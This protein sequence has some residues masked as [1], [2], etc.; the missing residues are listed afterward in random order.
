MLAKAPGFTLTV[1][2]TLGLGIGANAAVFSVINVLL[3]RPL[4]V[5]DGGNL[6]VLTSVHQGN[7]EPHTVS[8]KDYVDVREHAG[9]FSDLTA[10]GFGF[11]GMSVDGH[12]ERIAVSYVTGNYFSMLGIAPAYGRLILPTEGQTY[13]ADPVIVLGHSYWKKRFNSDPNAIGRTVL[14]NAQ[15]FTVVGVVPETFTGTYAVVEFDAY[16]PFGMTFPRSAYDEQTTQ[17]DNHELRILGRLKPGL[18]TTQAQ[19]A[20]DVVGRQLEEQYPD[21]NKTVRFRM[22]PERLSRPE[23]NNADNNPFVAG[24]FLML[25]GLVVLVACVNVVNLLMVR[26][27]GRHRELAIRAALGAGRRRLMRQLLTESLLLAAI[28]GLTGAVIGRLMSGLI[29]RIDYPA[30]LPIRFDVGFDWRVFAYIAAVALTTGIIVGLIPALRASRADVNEALREGGRGFADGGTRHRLRNALVI[31]Q[32]AVSLV[33]LIA[34]GLFVRSVQSAQSADLGF[35]HAN[36]LTLSMDVS[37]LAFDEARGR[38]LYREIADRV[39][40]LPGVANSSYASSVPFGYSSSSE[41]IEAEGQPIPKEQRRPIA[42][43]NLIGP[44]FFPTMKIPIVRGRGFT[45]DDNESSRPVA[46]VNEFMANKFW[47]GQDP[48]GKR[49]HTATNPSRWLE[50]VGVTKQGK[51]N[52]IFEDPRSFYFAPIEQQYS[53]RR[54]LQV[55]TAV[56]PESL[57]PVIQKEVRAIEPNLPL[58]DVRSMRR[59]LDGGNGFFLLNMGA[60]FGGG[61]GVLGLALALVG[62]YGVVSYTASQ[63][64]QEIGVRMALGAQPRDILTVVVG[65]GLLLVAAGLAV[66]LVGAFAVSRLL[67]NLL[68]GIST[69]DPV[70][71]IGVPVTLG[72]MALI[73]SYI[74][75][76]RAVRIDPVVALRQ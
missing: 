40:R 56:A 13:G 74:P 16:L 24:V 72:L 4:P 55:R 65:H 64:T 71:F 60:L 7:E 22:I 58:Y 44:E 50:V 53:A 9:A 43:T 63:R 5:R 19:A 41:L 45:A 18:S 68:F 46:I 57:I 20:I 49:F 32:V 52:Y 11:A 34:A 14:V 8:W 35:D 21:T 54:S 33:V 38:T 12:A 73:A 10:V 1:A 27:T 37:Q 47:P 76:L 3:L 36:V 17:R 2:L 67:T 23:P 15:P 39:G 70:T 42:G 31:A 6:Y 48:I 30:D 59:M 51:Y 69:L 29:A 75:A 62:I 28:G 26:A 25:V 61:L 66:G